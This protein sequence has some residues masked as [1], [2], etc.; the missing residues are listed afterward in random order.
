[1]QMSVGQTEL[2]CGVFCHWVPQNMLRYQTRGTVAMIYVRY[3]LFCTHDSFLL[4][5]FWGNYY[6]AFVGIMHHHHVS[7]L[8]HFGSSQ[9]PARIL[10]AVI[11]VQCTNCHPRP[12]LNCT[13]HSVRWSDWQLYFVSNKSPH[14]GSLLATF[15]TIMVVGTF[16]G[17]CGQPSAVAGLMLPCWSLCSRVP[18]WHSAVEVKLEI[19]GHICGCTILI[20][21]KRKSTYEYPTVRELTL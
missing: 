14:G 16:K 20:G 11:Q 9:R 12:F 10:E 7:D 5:S 19:L 18:Q 15:R 6:R 13:T 4:T 8:S 21:Q 3:L 2:D 17:H 1:M